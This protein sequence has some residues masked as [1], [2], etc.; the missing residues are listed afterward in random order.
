MSES[1]PIDHME[2]DKAESF[3]AIYNFCRE[4][5]MAAGDDPIEFYRRVAKANIDA[6][7]HIRDLVFTCKSLGMEIGQE[8][9]MQA[10]KRFILSLTKIEVPA[11][12]ESE[13]THPSPA[14]ATKLDELMSSPFDVSPNELADAVAKEVNDGFDLKRAASRAIVHAVM[15]ASKNHNEQLASAVSTA[16]EEGRRQGAEMKRRDLAEVVHNFADSIEKGE[17]S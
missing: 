5:G 14:G 9:E 15:M 10:V 7:N 3:V 2:R 13:P 17:A 6:F 8:T 12:E 4:K 11:E 16:M 1:S